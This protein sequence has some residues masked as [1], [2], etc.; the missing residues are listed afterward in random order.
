MTEFNKINDDLSVSAQ[1]LPEDMPAVA[2][3]GFKMVLN[4]RPDGEAADQPSSNEMAVAAEAAVLAYA[5]QP[6]V[7]ANIAETDIDGFDAIVSLAETPVLAFCRTGTRSTTLWALAQAS[8]QDNASILAT[9]EQAG[10]DLSGLA[11]RLN[12]RREQ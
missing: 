2:A 11:D 4:N 12:Q 10:Y 3:A 7:G 8:E 9:A 5:H 6:V 1:L